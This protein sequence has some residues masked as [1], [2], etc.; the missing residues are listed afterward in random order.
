M[1]T[2]PEKI[3]RE[4]SDKLS[5]CITAVKDLEVD[6]TIQK[7]LL[8]KVMYQLQKKYKLS[9][10]DSIDFETCEIKRERQKL[11]SILVST[12]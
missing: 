8:Q 12:L 4:E 2:K 1:T 9:D 3:T 7:A 5:N 11:K 10:T 6:I